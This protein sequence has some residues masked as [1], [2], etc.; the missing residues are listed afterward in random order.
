MQHLCSSSTAK[1]ICKYHCDYKQTMTRHFLLLVVFQLFAPGLAQVNYSPTRG[2]HPNW[3][4]CNQ[5]YTQLMEEFVSYYHSGP[6]SAYMPF[7]D[8]CYLAHLLPIATSGVFE[9][10]DPCDRSSFITP[11]TMSNRVYCDMTTRGGGWTVILRS[12]TVTATANTSSPIISPTI[13]DFHNG[14]GVPEGD[15]WLGLNTLAC[16]TTIQHNE[17]LVKLTFADGTNSEIEYEHFSIASMSN[18]CR[19]TANGPSNRSLDGLGSQNGKSFVK[20]P[21]GAWWTCKESTNLFS[22]PMMWKNRT[23]TS[24]EA[25]IRPDYYTSLPEC[26]A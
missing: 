26:P 5:R 14:Y 8:C 19:L 4:T 12:G 2:V 17:L 25:M 3:D 22:N 11:F 18:G 7:L 9:I 21:N 6:C 23:V 13:E 10:G 20:C 15:Y 1:L 16:I 24:A